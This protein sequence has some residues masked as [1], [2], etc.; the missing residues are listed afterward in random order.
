[1][2]LLDYFKKK[3][4]PCISSAGVINNN[5]GTCC[6]QVSLCVYPHNNYNIINVPGNISREINL[7]NSE[8]EQ[9][10][11]MATDISIYADRLKELFVGPHLGSNAE[12]CRLVSV[13][14]VQYTGTA[15]CI[16]NNNYCHFLKKY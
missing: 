4:Q 1:M 3:T 8:L 5:G 13:F 10:F 7:C 12:H 15:K 14:L 11:V 16:V 6:L 9:D 2:Q